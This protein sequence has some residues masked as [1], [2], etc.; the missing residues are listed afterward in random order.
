LGRDQYLG[1]EGSILMKMAAVFPVA[2]QSGADLRAAGL[3]RFLNEMM[4]FP[5]AF[6]GDNVRWRPVDGNSAEVTIVDRGMT[7]AA[8][9]FFDGDGRPVNFVAQRYNTDTRRA[10]TW[11]TPI[12]DYGVLGGLNLP[13]KGKAV[14]KLAGGDFTYIEL[15]ITGVAYDDAARQR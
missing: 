9:M 8:V 4:W 10:E 14:W 12:T 7:A 11:E 15:E 6:A 5:A 13:A 3:M 2:D 1:G